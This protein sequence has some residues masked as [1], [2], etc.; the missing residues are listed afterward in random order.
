MQNEDLI[1]SYL[2]YLK[3]EKQY[4]INTIKSYQNDLNSFMIFIGNK[5][6]LIN[7]SKDEIKKYIYSLNQDGK[8][9][10]TIAH[11]ITVLR[12]FY[13]FLLKEGKIKESPLTFI[14]LPKLSKTIPKVLSKGEVEQLLSF[15][16]TDAFSYRNKAMLELLYATGLRVSEL[17]NLKVSDI[18]L[19]MGVVRTIGKGNKERI[20][21]FGDYA[22][23]ALKEYLL[24]YRD[25]MLKNKYTD[26]L[27]LNNHGAAMTRQ[28]C[29][30][31]I[32]KI[33][34]EVGIKKE[35][36]PHT[37][38]HSFATHLLDYGADLRSIQEMLGHSSIQTTQIY[39]HVSN[40]HLKDNYHSFHPHG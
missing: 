12:N 18:N 9:E 37:L 8:K 21:P 35:F 6:S 31:M 24:Y 15:P 19:N 17:I 26:I 23:A 33:A 38:R 28:G 4:S 39:T 20:I 14:E 16:L 29:F 22:E 36:S 5:K 30:K 1:N 32:K 10:K 25:G 34:K 11:Q 40:E 3:V 2:E 7:L 27:F 13:K